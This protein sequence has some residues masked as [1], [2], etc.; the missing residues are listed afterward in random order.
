VTGVIA[1]PD[2]S[3]CV[4]ASVGLIHLFTSSGRLLR[5]CGDEVTVALETPLAPALR[6]DWIPAEGYAQMREAFYALVATKAD[7]FWAATPSTLHHFEHSRHTAHPMPKLKPFA[8]VQMSR[9]L[10]GLIVVLSE[11]DHRTCAPCGA[12]PFLVA[13]D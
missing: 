7:G 12:T 6:P 1:D 2:S 8:G 3:D 5:V 4:Y 11:A 10:P 9:D 13:E